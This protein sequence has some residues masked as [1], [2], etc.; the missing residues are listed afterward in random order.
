[1]QNQEIAIGISEDLEMGIPARDDEVIPIGAPENE[2]NDTF[3]GETLNIENLSEPM[4]TDQTIDYLADNQTPKGKK[5]PSWQR[6]QNAS[7]ARYDR[8]TSPY[9]LRKHRLRPREYQ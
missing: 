6:D 3:M 7:Y 2:P 5:I 8:V 9:G 4:E 1:M